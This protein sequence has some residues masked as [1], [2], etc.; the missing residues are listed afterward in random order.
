MSNGIIRPLIG[1]VV[2]VKVLDI[3]GQTIKATSPRRRKKN[4]TKRRRK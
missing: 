2:A 3:L 1:A 4:K